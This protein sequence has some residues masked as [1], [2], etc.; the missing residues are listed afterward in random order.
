[1]LPEGFGGVPREQILHPGKRRKRLFAG[2]PSSHLLTASARRVL[3]QGIADLDWPLELRELGMALYLDRPLGIFKE[4]GAVDRTPLLSYEAF[5]R[6]IA[7]GRLQALRG[8]GLV[9]EESQLE[10]LRQKL[11]ERTPV[12]GLPVSGLGGAAQ[13]GTVA[14]EDAQIAA[15][16]FVFLRTTRQSLKQFFS[17]YEFDSL[18]AC[19]PG[20]TNWLLS[21][22]RVLLIRTGRAPVPDT[23]GSF[24]VA[25]DD[26]MQPR[27]EFGLGQLD[28]AQVRYVEARGVEYLEHGFRVLRVWEPDG[29]G[30]SWRER[31][32]CANEVRVPPHLP[33]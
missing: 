21:A 29:A 4:P 2:D 26:R 10:G 7:E 1:M 20:P 18:A 24:L 8:S 25:F 5:S 27:M 23:V 11:R 31:D 13:R 16:D 12:R 14:L 30:N 3:E 15:A 17:H 22:Q 32:Q 33:R 6:K 28:A 19:A 9:S